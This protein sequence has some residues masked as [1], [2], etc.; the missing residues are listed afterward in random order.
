VDCPLEVCQQRD[1]KGLY[2]K[3]ISGEIPAFTGISAP[4]E[5]P[6]NPEIHLHTDK[7]TIDDCIKSIIEKL[8]ISRIIS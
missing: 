7:Q 4:Y 5:A 8:Q 2:Q 3:A 1:T 6:E